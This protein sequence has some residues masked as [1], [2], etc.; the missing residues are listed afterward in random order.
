[1]NNYQA[2]ALLLALV[3]VI[4]GAGAW[5]ISGFGGSF[6][7][8]WGKNLWAIAIT[9]VITVAAIMAVEYGV[10]PLWLWLG[11]LE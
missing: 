5:V 1:M 2:V 7:R 10:A 8:M 3:L 11:T 9:F 6:W 4:T